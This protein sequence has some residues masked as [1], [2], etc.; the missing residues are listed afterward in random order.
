MITEYGRP[1]RQLHCS[2]NYLITDKG[3][4]N[5]GAVIICLLCFVAY[6]HKFVSVLKFV[7]LI[8]VKLVL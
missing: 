2:M 1:V 5:V 7:L 3:I 4:G 8:S 6:M